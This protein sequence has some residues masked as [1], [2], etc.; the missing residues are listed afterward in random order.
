M[1]QA[2]VN[3]LFPAFNRWQHGPYRCHNKAIEITLEDGKD[4][5]KILTTRVKNPPWALTHGFSVA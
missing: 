4:T 1:T 2:Y 5:G 3:G